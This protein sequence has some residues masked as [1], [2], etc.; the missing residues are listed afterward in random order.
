MLLPC[1]NSITNQTKYRFSSW[2]TKSSMI[3]LLPLSLAFEEEDMSSVMSNSLRPRGLQP[4]RLL[5][6]LDFSGKNT[7]VGC[8][9]LLQGIFTTQGLKPCL[10]CLLHQQADSFTTE[11][12]G[13][14]I[15]SFISHQ[16]FLKTALDL[17][18]LQVTGPGIA[19]PKC[20][21]CEYPHHAFVWV[22]LKSDT[23]PNLSWFPSCSTGKDQALLITLPLPMHNPNRILD[24][25]LLYSFAYMS[26][27]C[28][29]IF[30]DQAVTYLSLYPLY[31]A[32]FM[33]IVNV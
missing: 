25:F 7:G 18:S 6:P 14:L 22:Q 11:P 8:H 33:H 17:P 9:F 19:L 28:V 5:C 21:P 29:E 26:F 27:P 31:L 23:S 1:L 24:H 10:L 12:P 2:L 15:S 4:A 16:I 3:F 13:K 32:Q 20:S 30:A